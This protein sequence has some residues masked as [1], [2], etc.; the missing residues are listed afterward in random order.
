MPSSSEVIFTLR[1]AGLGAAYQALSE[2]R[3]VLTIDPRR[4]EVHYRI[5][6]TLLNRYHQSQ[7]AQDLADAMTEFQEELNVNPANANAAYELAEMHRSAGQLDQALPF[8]QMAI[9]HYPDFQEAQVGLAA[10][11]MAQQKPAEAL[12]HLQKAASLN[13][14]DEVAWYRLSQAQ[15]A[16]GQTAEQK[17]SLAEFQ[18]L[19]SRN[20]N[21]GTQTRS[22]F[23]GDEVTRQTLDPAAAPQ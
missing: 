8:F 3:L 15:R 7:S 17:K 23:S 12:P 14:T 6:R 10:T 13:P 22:L 19:H 5:G 1:L 16:L 11:L 20:P 18:K 21:Q 2:Y 9:D 4:P